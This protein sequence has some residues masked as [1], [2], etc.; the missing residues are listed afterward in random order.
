[1]PS[2]NLRGFTKT[3]PPREPPQKSYL[4]RFMARCDLPLCSIFKKRRFKKPLAGPLLGF[5]NFPELIGIARPERHKPL[6]PTLTIGQI[7]PNSRLAERARNKQ[8][9]QTRSESGAPQYSSIWLLL[10]AQLGQ[11][12]QNKC[13]RKGQERLKTI[14]DHL[15][16]SWS[17]PA[18]PDWSS[19][20]L[21][22]HVSSGF[23]RRC[24]SCSFC[25]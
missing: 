13:R 21:I 12:L 17:G 2:L 9:L 4:S 5:E 20:L 10:T 3:D 18:R 22:R 23:L 6:R 1:M 24:K 25:Q 15:G 19:R 11:D 8:Q 14:T 7:R 16:L